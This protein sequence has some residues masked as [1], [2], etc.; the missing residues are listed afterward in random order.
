ML[1]FEFPQSYRE[2]RRADHLPLEF[3]KL[4]EIEFNREDTVN[5]WMRTMLEN[6]SLKKISTKSFLNYD[7]LMQLAD[8]L[9]SLV[10]FSF[11]LEVRQSYNIADIVQFMDRAKKLE[12]LS[13][14]FLYYNSWLNDFYLAL[15]REWKM[16]ENTTNICGFVRLH[17]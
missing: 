10:E 14:L 12:K 16:V 13:V 2:T 3:G 4:E 6:Q 1:R 8:G 17:V 11:K 5:F 7:Q 15:N 9:P